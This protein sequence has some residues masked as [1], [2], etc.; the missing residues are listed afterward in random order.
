MVST[1]IMLTLPLWR[2]APSDFAI[3]A[4]TT[5]LDHLIDAATAGQ[6]D[7]RLVPVRRGLVVDAIRRTEFLRPRQ[8]GVAR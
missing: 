6:C 5:D 1:P 7:R 4:C 8:L 3:V 2:I